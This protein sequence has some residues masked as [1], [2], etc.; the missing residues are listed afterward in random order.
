MGR[1]R[2]P[3][4]VVRRSVARKLAVKRAQFPPPAEHP[5]PETILLPWLHVS[6]AGISEVLRANTLIE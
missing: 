6:L 1:K 5:P 4:Y 2:P 3:T